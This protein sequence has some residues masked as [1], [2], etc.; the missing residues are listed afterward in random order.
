MRWDLTS[1]NLLK[2]HVFKNENQEIGLV[3]ECVKHF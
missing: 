1:R 2:V 3:A